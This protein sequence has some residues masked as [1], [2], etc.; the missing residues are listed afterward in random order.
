MNIYIKFQQKLYE[1]MVNCVIHF[2]IKTIFCEIQINK[3]MQ[4]FNTVNFR[5]K[6]KQYHSKKNQYYVH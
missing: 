4:L 3:N 2:A 6:N 1:D 5:C